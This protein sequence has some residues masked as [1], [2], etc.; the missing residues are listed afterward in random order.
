MVDHWEPLAPNGRWVYDRDFHGE[1]LETIQSREPVAEYPG[2]P[3]I[4]WTDETG[5]AVD[6]TL[7]TTP[8]QGG[9]GEY[10][11]AG[12]VEDEGGAVEGPLQ[13][14]VLGADEVVVILGGVHP[15]ASEPEMCEVEEPSRIRQQPLLFPISPG[16]VESRGL[17]SQREPGKGRVGV[18]N[19]G[20]G[21]SSSSS[22]GED[23]EEPADRQQHRCSVEKKIK[24][25]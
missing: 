24:Q 20:C 17:G 19:C 12:G 25:S 13:D 3:F 8:W 23:Q 7:N 4:E 6:Q 15:E 2:P 9:G 5:L 10:W 11:P 1:W 14:G 18:G 21:S 22:D 16:G